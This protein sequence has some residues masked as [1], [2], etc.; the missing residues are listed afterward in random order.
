[1]LVAHSYGCSALL[2]AYH[3][4]YNKLSPKVTHIILLDPYLFPLPD[5][6]LTKKI[7]CPVL[8]LANQ[9]FLN[10]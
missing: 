2:Q 9:Y 3:N 10:F 5:H 7:D 4:Y 1:M 8:I 6:L